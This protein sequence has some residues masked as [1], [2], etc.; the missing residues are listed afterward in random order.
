MGL[1]TPDERLDRLE[2]V[3]QILAEDHLHLKDIVTDLAT[4]SRRAFD[5]VAEQGRQADERFKRL[6]EQMRE[7]MRRIEEQMRRTEEQMRRTDEEFNR[8]EEQMRET[9]AQMRRTDKRVDDLVLAIGE[10]IRRL[11]PGAN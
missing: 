7:Q 8:T 1:K 9:A 2:Q 4:A 3:V 10:L 11:P 6:E 5:L